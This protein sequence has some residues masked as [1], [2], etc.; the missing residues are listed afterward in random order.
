M[1]HPLFLA[2]NLTAGMAVLIPRRMA[3]KNPRQDFL[4]RHMNC[5]SFS[6]LE[7]PKKRF[8]AKRGP[9]S[10]EVGHRHA[11]GCLW[12]RFFRQNGLYDPNLSG[13]FLSLNQGRGQATLA[14]VL[15]CPTG[16]A[17]NGN[18]YKKKTKTILLW[19]LP[20]IRAAA[21]YLT[22]VLASIRETW[23]EAVRKEIYAQR[24]ADKPC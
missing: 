21:S 11:R 19:K 23:L 17:M 5:N 18:S 6:R 20:Q 14:A 7:E 24:L 2:D 1:I 16:A 9:K 22:A 10:R 4:I 12:Q 13:R 15:A 8:G 3:K